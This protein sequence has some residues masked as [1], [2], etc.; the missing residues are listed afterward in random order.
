MT[1]ATA[2]ASAAITGTVLVAMPRRIVYMPA[3]RAARPSARRPTISG[4][5]TIV[6]RANRSRASRSA[7]ALDHS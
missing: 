5:R 4:G 7:C 3:K 6:S 2:S 1:S